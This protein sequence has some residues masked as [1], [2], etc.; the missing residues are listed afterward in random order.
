MKL[1]LKLRIEILLSIV[2]SF[3]IISCVEVD[4]T[5][6]ST[7]NLQSPVKFIN[8]ASSSIPMA[9]N[10]DGS[11][12]A[13]VAYEAQSSY[14]NLPSG[15]RLFSFTYDSIVDTI[16]LALA[17]NYKF[18][19]FG[20]ST[21][22]GGRTYFLAAER[23]TLEGAQAYTPGAVT[24]H[25]FNLSNDTAATISDGVTFLLS[26]GT[27]ADTSS[28]AIPFS[29]STPYYQV[30]TSVNPAFIVVGAEDD[31]LITSTAVATVDGR[32]S[33]VLYG[34]KTAN[35]LKATVYKED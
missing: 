20:A 5:N 32:Y 6:V 29:I 10:V 9:V 34:S 33:V 31:T 26:R 21:P 1:F 13:T 27:S 28:S 15:S 2:L 4:N 17:P 11:N 12:I 18:T 19:C 24:V 8:F 30:A 22:N 25:F 14:S 7:V 3:Y 23:L 35:T 16:R